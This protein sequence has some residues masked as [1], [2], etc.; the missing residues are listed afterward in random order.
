MHNHNQEQIA[1]CVFFYRNVY[2][3]LSANILLLIIIYAL[4]RS[5]KEMVF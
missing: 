4:T 2:A 5:T 3:L 1:V